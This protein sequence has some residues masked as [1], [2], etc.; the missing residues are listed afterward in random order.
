MIHLGNLELLHSFTQSLRQLSLVKK[1][2]QNFPKVW[3]ERT[4]SGMFQEFW[5][6]SFH[7][8]FG[9]I[10][11]NSLVRFVFRD[12]SLLAFC[13]KPLNHA[14]T[15][16]LHPHEEKPLQEQPKRYLSFYHTTGHGRYF[17]CTAA[18]QENKKQNGTNRVSMT[19]PLLGRAHCPIS[20][21][22]DDDVQHRWWS[23]RKRG[24][25]WGS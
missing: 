23:A 16:L 19:L 25:K 5:I 7:L 10:W 18:L 11:R 9:S 3:I 17:R 14:Y 24:S 22:I 13:Q 4:V 6:P 12:D 1:E 20:M 15:C 2:C 8:C 21:D